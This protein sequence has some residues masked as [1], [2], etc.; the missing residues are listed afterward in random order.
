VKKEE[1]EREKRK[2]EVEYT[3]KKSVAFVCIF[4]AAIIFLSI[5][6]NYVFY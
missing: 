4:G 2:I 6:K 1:F 3:F 5:L